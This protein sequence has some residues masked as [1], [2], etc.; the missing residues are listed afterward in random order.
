MTLV[1]P[2]RRR[3][4]AVIGGG[5]AGIAAAVQATSLGHAVDLFEMAP[6]LGGRAR[7]FEVDGVEIDNGQH[8]AIGAYAQTLALMR[9]VGADPVQAFLRMPLRLVDANGVGLRLRPGP[10]ALAFTAAVLAHRGWSTRDKLA[11]LGATTRWALQGFRCDAGHTVDTLCVR[12]SA[13]VRDELI[14]PLCV[15]ALNTASHE[16]SAGVFLRVLREALFGGRGASDLLLPRL[17]L[18]RVLADPA[19]AWLRNAGATIHPG[20]RVLR[21]EPQAHG[22][23]IDGVEV[24]AAVLATSSPEAARLTQ[25]VAAEWARKAASLEHEPIVTV[26]ARCAGA[27]LSEPMLRLPARPRPAPAQFVFDR[28][29]L[30]GPTGLLAFVISGAREW[31]ARGNDS[32]WLAIQAQAARCLNACGEGRLELLKIVT[33]HRATFRCLPGLVRPGQAIAPDLVAAADFVE[34]PYPAT[35]EGAV[36]SGADAI[37]LLAASAPPR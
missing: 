20:C 18:S 34:G 11:L 28:G 1:A 32:L 36:R 15:A 13:N 14:A 16:A 22:W 24:D 23:L 9:R 33:E 21:L 25:P 8:I 10:P 29:Q 17:P 3:R 6:Q 31:V 27:R 4:I 5:W 19:A 12:L 26:Y 35:L 2:Q 37:D 7:S 30:G